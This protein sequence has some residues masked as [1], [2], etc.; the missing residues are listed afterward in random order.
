[1]SPDLER[2]ARRLA[3]RRAREL[4]LVRREQARAPERPQVP[5]QAPVRH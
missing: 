2:R 5:G 4:V 3:A 1:M